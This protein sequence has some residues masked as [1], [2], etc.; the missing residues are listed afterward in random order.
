M[1]NITISAELKSHF[2]QLY[3]IALLEGDFG[4]LELKMLYDFAEERGISR[5][6]L[7]AL[8]LEPQTNENLIPESIEKK[9]EY[10]CDFTAMIWV[11]Q[12][13]TADERSAL[14]KYI[15]SFGFLDENIAPLADYLIE[16]IKTD[17]TKHQIINELND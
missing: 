12:I 6:H 8:L 11:D 9:I 1:E 3:Q 10:L 16:A 13:I 5:T 4:T 17:K 15:K 7:D 14:E 2:L